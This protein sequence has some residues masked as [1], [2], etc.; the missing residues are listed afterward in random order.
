MMNTFFV[1]IEHTEFC[2]VVWCGVVKM[3]VVFYTPR[4]S[5]R[6]LD[7]VLKNTQKFRGHCACVQELPAWLPVT[8]CPD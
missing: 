2:C 8:R 4:S 7:R 5:L 6:L 3:I 1:F